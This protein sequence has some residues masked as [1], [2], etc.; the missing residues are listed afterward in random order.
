MIGTNGAGSRLHTV[1]TAARRLVKDGINVRESARTQRVAEYCAVVLSGC[2]LH[3]KVSP[4]SVHEI[5]GRRFQLA[6]VEADIAQGAVIELVDAGELGAI[7]KISPDGVEK[8]CSEHGP[9]FPLSM[10][11]VRRRAIARIGQVNRAL[12]RS[13]GRQEFP[14]ISSRLADVW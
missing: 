1:R 6:A 10:S 4:R 7:A 5:P 2:D 8:K 12:R 9:G 13:S 14:S 11:M 3:P